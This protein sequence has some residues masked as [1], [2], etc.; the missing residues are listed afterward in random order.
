MSYKGVEYPYMDSPKSGGRIVL[1]GMDMHGMLNVIVERRLPN[2]T[3][4]VVGIQYS[5]RTG[6]WAYGHYHGTFD[7]ALADWRESCKYASFDP[8]NEKDLEFERTGR[9]NYNHVG[10]TY[11]QEHDYRDPGFDPYSHSD[12]ESY[13]V[14]YDG[15]EPGRDGFERYLAG[16]IQ[17]NPNAKKT[18]RRVFR[19]LR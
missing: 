4:W 12:Y 2:R 17:R 3:E 15:A 13:L 16:Y 8:E 9:F 19:W 10:M 1:R 7:D 5:P 18:G 14:R 6:Q 11:L